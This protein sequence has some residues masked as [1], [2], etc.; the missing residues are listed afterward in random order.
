MIRWTAFNLKSPVFKVIRHPTRAVA[1]VQLVLLW[2]KSYF[3]AQKQADLSRADIIQKKIDDRVQTQPL[4][5]YPYLFAIVYILYIG[6]YV[7]NQFTHTQYLAAYHAFRRLIQE[8]CKIFVARPTRMRDRSAV[9]H[10]LLRFTQ[11]I[12]DQTNCY[13]SMHVSLVVL[14]YQILKDG[15][16]K[17]PLR[18]EAMRHSCIDISRSTL[19]TK[20]HSII[21]VIGGHEIARQ[22]YQSQFEG[23]FEN[24][25][26]EILT[27]LS[28][29]EHQTIGR[30]IQQ[31]PDLIQLLD[32]LLD[33]FSESAPGI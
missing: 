14:S 3:S 4:A 32:H 31:N 5:I 29:Q 8:S 22:I 6:W 12:D 15:H 2:I 17:D 20:Q 7:L 13:P 1:L 10:P 24:L 19:Q 25:L 21:D 9:S 18:L 27:E 16:E 30:L 28:E 23:S 11:T 33:L 26:P